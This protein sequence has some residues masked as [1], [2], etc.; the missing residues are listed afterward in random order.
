VPSS[1]WTERGAIL[2]LFYLHLRPYKPTY[3]PTINA[4]ITMPKLI[5]AIHKGT[6]PKSTVPPSGRAT[7]RQNE[8][9][10]ERG[11]GSGT[12]VGFENHHPVKFVFVE[13]KSSKNK[14]KKGQRK[15]R[16]YMKTDA[17]KLNEAHVFSTRGKPQQM[18]RIN[19]I[20]GSK[21]AG[22]GTAVVKREERRRRCIVNLRYTV[23]TAVTKSPS[24]GSKNG[25]D[26]TRGGRNHS[27]FKISILESEVALLPLTPRAFPIEIH[28]HPLLVLFCDR[29]RLGMSLEPREVLHVEPPR[30]SLQLFGREVL[31]IRPRVVIEDVKQRLDVQL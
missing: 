28:V 10:M 4:H 15:K 16:L 17:T 2:W 5:E 21:T 24:D 9:L 29:L 26:L 19:S 6:R 20:S 3:H 23:G 27:I 31:L 14:T 8:R 13:Y 22:V 7:S 11:S 12:K 18:E 25:G 30:L 1:P